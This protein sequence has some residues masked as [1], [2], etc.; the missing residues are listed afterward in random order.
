MNPSAPRAQ[1][2]AGAPERVVVAPERVVVFRDDRIGDLLVS[3]PIFA[4][5]RARH[6]DSHITLVASPL[7]APTLQGLPEIDEIVAYDRRWRFRQKRAFLRRL[8]AGRPSTTIVL[9]PANEVYLLA[10]LSGARRRGGLLRPYRRLALQLLA[11]LLLTHIERVGRSE[12]APRHHTEVV[13][14]LAAQMGFP[15]SADA[16]LRVPVD[17]AARASIDAALARFRPDAPLFIVQLATKPDPAAAAFCGPGL[18]DLVRTL[19][20]RHPAARFALVG[21][22]AERGL[23]AQLTPLFDQSLSETPIVRAST[24][25]LRGGLP[26]GMP[27]GL[28]GVLLFD[29]PSF[30]EWSALVA[31]ADLVVTPDCG[32][33]HL[34]AAHGRPVVVIYAPARLARACAEFGPWQVPFRAVAADSE[35]V[36]AASVPAAVAEVLAEAA[37]AATA[38]AAKLAA[39]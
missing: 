3:S 1:P 13:L 23:L 39:N 24:S 38:A 37:N 4:A 21:G 9:S 22:A 2:D 33:V 29:Q 8:R 20:R 32:A 16:P 17:P 18:L 10:L 19:Q 27:G 31:S 36:I 15:V 35:A 25:P 12:T 11:P 26:G 6:P 14:A 5:I 7:N 30:A 28:P 34:A